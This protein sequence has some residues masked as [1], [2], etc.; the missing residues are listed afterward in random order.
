MLFK[1]ALCNCTWKSL[2]DVESCIGD[3]MFKLQ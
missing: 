1:K 3:F 2:Y